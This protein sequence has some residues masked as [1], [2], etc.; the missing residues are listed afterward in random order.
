MRSDHA[1]HSRL[2]EVAARPTSKVELDKTDLKLLELLSQDAR[3]SQRQLAQSIG[4]SAPT[5]GERIGRLE[6]LG[7]IEGYSVQ[8]NWE[9]VGYGVTVYLSITASQ[10]YDVSKVMEGLWEV[11]EVEEIYVITGQLDLLARL[12]VRDHAHLR[13]LLMDVIWQI[14][15]LKGTETGVAMAE[16]PPKAFASGIFAQ[17]AQLSEGKKGESGHDG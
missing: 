6:R 17:L 12:R 5:V 9:A 11:T 13:D 1:S 8:V 7:L 16:M 3:T 2:R 4:V 15:G 14:P 10:G